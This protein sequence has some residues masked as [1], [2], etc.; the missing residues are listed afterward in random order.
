[1]D[2]AAGVT[3]APAAAAR[4]VE[5]QAPAAP[6]AMFSLVI[7][8]FLCSFAGTSTN[9]AI[10][11]IAAD[12]STS[13]QVIQAAITL[14]TLSMAALMIPGSKLTDIVGRKRCFTIGLI[15]YG[16][17]ALVAAAAPG[18][19]VFILGYSLG[20][21][22]G[23]SLL[24]P[25]VY[26]F[27][28]VLFTGTVARARAFGL[29]S[30]AAGV[31]SAAG[32]LIGGLITSA[33]SWRVTF[34]VQALI[35]VVILI[36]GRKL[37]ETRSTDRRPDFD[38]LGAALSAVGLILI[39]VGVLLTGT[40]GWG[41]TV[42]GETPADMPRLGS[43]TISPVWPSVV[44]G[45]VAILLFFR[46]VR[47]VERAGGTPLLASRILMN[48]VAN[49]GLVTQNTQWLILQGMA[50]V[51]S[52][53]LQTVQGLNAVQTGLVL[54]PAT[55]GILIASALAPRMAARRA[56]AVLIRA[57]FV[58][59]IAGIGLILLLANALDSTLALL[60]G[61]L[62]IGLGTGVMLTSS[63]NVVQSS[64]PEADQ[65]EISGLS[66]SISNLGSSLGVAIAGSVVVSS[67]FSGNQGYAY[68]LVVLGGVRRDRP[69]R[70]PAP[71]IAKACPG[72]G[73]IRRSGGRL[74]A[75]WLPS[76]PWFRD[77]RGR[78]G[79]R[80]STR[81]PSGV[82]GTVVRE[83][84]RISVERPDVDEAHAV[85]AR[86]LT[87]EPLA[88]AEHDRKD[89]QPHLVDEVV[90]DQHADNP[91]AGRDDDV[92]V[93][94]HLQLRDLAQ[95]VALDDRRVVPVGTLEG[96]RHHVLGHAV[97]PVRQRARAGWPSRGEPFVGPPA[98]QHGVRSDG[99][100]EREL[101]ELRAVLDQAHPTT[102]REAF[103]T[104]WVLDDS[105]ERDV[106]A[107]RRSCPFRTCS[108]GCS[109]H[110]WTAAQTIRAAPCNS[111]VSC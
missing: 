86:G 55:I 84:R 64:F 65:G 54:T 73:A 19:G 60:P 91:G 27:A 20:Q 93:E 16:A 40:Y 10:T 35:V 100:V 30:A 1:M 109:G 12:L 81:R 44:L 98:H 8:Q 13:V 45:L 106:V 101:G 58:M 90:F 110:G 6:L 51:V 22:I 24:I 34:V 4:P 78:Y 46:H 36:L 82:L 79:G 77:L 107:D 5:S 33:T 3:Q 67:A 17:G 111:S 23:T 68:A 83:E 61:L 53:Y 56:Q 2:G 26:I 38:L 48:R 15:V 62:V 31:G 108:F 11:T 66:R 95:H 92:P 104:G 88:G 57:G 37:V 72:P 49:L 96:R 89:L 74:T 50:F 25:P 105:V 97:Q 9:V 18:P 102:A 94:V 70:R 42:S 32:P 85:H 7:A 41:L 39:V 103:V 99:F 28:T 63:V 71:A 47:S 59:T 29:I 14:F 75:A 43:G 52:V 69:G 21:G 76:T 80:P 87:E